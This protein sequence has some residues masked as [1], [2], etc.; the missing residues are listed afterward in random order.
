MTVD[1]EQE[2]EL[3][4]Y[5]ESL[6][7]QMVR[8]ALEEKKV[9][10]KHHH[11]HLEHNAE[12]LTK[13]FLAVNPKA[14]VPV[15]VHNGEVHTDSWKIIRY[16]DKLFPDKGTSLWPQDDEKESRLE[17]MI[18]DNNLDETNEVVSNFGGSVA[19]ASTYILADI[20]KTRP[21]WAVAWDYLKKHPDKTRAS[22]FVLIRLLGKPPKAIY[23]KFIKRLAPGLVGIEQ[24]L[25]Q[26]GDYILGDYSA[27]DV[28]MTAHYHRLE[29][30][31][32]G[33]LLQSD[34]FPNIKS[35]WQRLQSRPSYKTAIKDL[36]IIH[37]RGAIERVYGDNPN[38][39][40]PLL[41]EEIR[42]LGYEVR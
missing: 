33:S 18:L 41:K 31:M 29:D 32:L 3:Y 30:V 1:Y 28:M 10:Y 38:P 35:Y 4:S 24:A 20:L 13:A 25:A 21:F 11:I 36:E 26:G 7:S 14:L 17:D 15:L 8:V 9:L 39:F 12:N 22:I 16:L 2:F 5:G 6:C 37:W 19:G 23:E 42:N 40:L 27:V 34:D